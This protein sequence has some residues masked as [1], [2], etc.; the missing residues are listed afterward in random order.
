[1]VERSRGGEARAMGDNIS[2]QA[3]IDVINHE[4]RCG[5][6]ID[7]CGLETAH[8]LIEELPSV[9]RT[10]GKW[11]WNPDGMD[12][13]IGAWVCSNCRHKPETWWECD[14]R[15]NPLN[16]SGSHFCG[17]CGADMRGA[18]DESTI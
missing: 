9:D 3:A 13:N 17:N 8:D 6:V 12:W 15:Y 7:Q 18:D 11:V 16:R 5:A 2:R 4:L 14:E 1:M 10:E